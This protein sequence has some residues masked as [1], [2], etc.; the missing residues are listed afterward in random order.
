MSELNRYIMD[1][2]PSYYH[3]ALDLDIVKKFLRPIKND[4]ILTNDTQKCYKM[5]EVW[6]ENDGTSATWNKLCYALEE[7]DKH[8]LAKKIRETIILS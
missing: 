7:N 3:I 5:L 2:A 4:P 1:M 8:E 6:L